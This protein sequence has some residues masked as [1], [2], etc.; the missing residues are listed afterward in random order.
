MNLLSLI[1]PSL[2]HV[3]CGATLSNHGLNRL[4]KF[5]SI[6][7]GMA[8]WEIVESSRMILRMPMYRDTLHQIK[9]LLGGDKFVCFGAK[10]SKDRLEPMTAQIP[11]LSSRFLCI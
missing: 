1:N 9:F 7:M 4:K 5:V 8:R 10:I 11:P 2:A 3:Y 6:Y